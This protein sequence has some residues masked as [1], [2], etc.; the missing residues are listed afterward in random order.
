MRFEHALLT[1]SDSQSGSSH[2]PYTAAIDNVLEWDLI[3]AAQLKASP[4]RGREA[5]P[6][7]I[8]GGLNNIQKRIDSL[9]PNVVYN[10]HRSIQGRSMYISHEPSSDQATCSPLDPLPYRAG[11]SELS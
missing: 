3:P 6:P 8:R 5:N 7:H 10:D 4:I 1:S 2:N 11:L 9:T